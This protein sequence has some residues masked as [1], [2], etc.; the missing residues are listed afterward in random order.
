MVGLCLRGCAPS[1]FFKTVLDQVSTIYGVVE[2]E[3][4]VVERQ[5][6]RSAEGW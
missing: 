2:C 5:H 1:G 3:E 4:R 6:P